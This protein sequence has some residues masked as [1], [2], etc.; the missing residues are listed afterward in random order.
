MKI[1]I[2]KPHDYR[3][4]PAVIQ[5]FRPGVVNVPKTTAQALIAAGA[6]LPITTQKETG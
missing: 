6:A 2:I 1:Q 5:A 4:R 3:V